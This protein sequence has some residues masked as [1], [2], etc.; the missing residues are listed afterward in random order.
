MLHCLNSLVSII[1]SKKFEKV[2]QLMAMSLAQD[3]N[4]FPFFAPSMFDYICGKD[5]GEITVDINHVPDYEAR[6][7]LFKVI[8]VASSED[9]H[10]IL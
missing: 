2:G 6:D 8:I 5:V 9:D 1:Q 10:Y 3:G 7:F 4:G